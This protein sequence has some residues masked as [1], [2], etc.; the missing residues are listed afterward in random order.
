M[1]AK[2]QTISEEDKLVAPKYINAF[3]SIDNKSKKVKVA[4]SID[5]LDIDG[6]TFFS[7]N[8]RRLYFQCDFDQL[9]SINQYLDSKTIVGTITDQQQLL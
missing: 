7:F 3:F 2:L 1:D 6:D 4:K 9:C 5:L 8:I